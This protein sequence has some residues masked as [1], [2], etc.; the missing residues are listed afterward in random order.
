MTLKH[1]LPIAM[2]AVAV[3]PAAAQENL[4]LIK[5][6]HVVGTYPAGDVDYL[7][8]KKPA[9]IN[10]DPI[11]IDVDNVGKNT[12][13]FTINTAD[14]GTAYAYA[15]ISYYDANY[16]AMDYYD[17]TFDDLPEGTQ[18]IVLSSLLYSSAYV[19]QGNRTV[20][21]TDF[22][23]DGTSYMGQPGRFNVKPGCTYYATAL[24]V[25]PVSQEPKE[26]VAT[27]KLTTLEPGL[28]DMSLSASFVKQ[29]NETLEFD[30]TGD[31]KCEYV[32]TCY[33]YTEMMESFI[34]MYGY[35]YVMYTFGQQFTL[36][37]LR[38]EGMEWPAY[39]TGDYS[40]YVQGFDAQGNIKRLDPVKAHYEGTQTAEGPTITIF[41][42]EKREGYVSVNFEISPSNVEEAYVIMMPEND[43]DD[44][45]NDGW[46]LYE[47]ASSS[48]ATDITNQ[49]NTM[50]EYTFT[51][52]NVSEQ[53]Q[54][55]LIYAV[56]K[57]G[58]RTVARINF[59]PDP[60]SYWSIDTKAEK[61]RRNGKKL[62][63]RHAMKPSAD[64]LK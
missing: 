30:V 60:D 42:K 52:S 51:D 63:I 28:S 47:I 15:L 4:Y 3:L 44:R 11:W 19:A 1:I 29:G 36:E 8:F 43:V 57:D 20:T 10:D 2:F 46:K 17:S 45:L 56:D 62:N 26:F 59:F 5:G 25:D 35:D 49:I 21:M 22:E 41:S 18:Q 12:V 6:Q 32:I 16:Y 13:T 61:P 55:I 34:E 7:S 39:E 24:E 38:E 33:G 50:G 64:K 48:K 31:S 27:A 37:E 40:L 58:N 54:S 23:L 53:W 14:L 9:D